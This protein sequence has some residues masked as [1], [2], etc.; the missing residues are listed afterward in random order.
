MIIE[1]GNEEFVIPGEPRNNGFMNS[2][3]KGINNEGDCINIKTS[4]FNKR[5]LN[6]RAS[7]DENFPKAL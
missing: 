3:R 4:D 7:M 6:H 5:H 2:Q 1:S